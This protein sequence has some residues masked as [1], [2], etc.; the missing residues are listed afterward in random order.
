MKVIVRYTDGRLIKGFTKD[1]FPDR[2]CFHLYP[3]E[4]PQ[5]EPVEIHMTSLKAVFFVREF[6]GDDSYDERKTYMEGEN[7]S[8]EKVRVTFKDDEVMIG[9]TLGYDENRPGFFIF[10]ADPHSNNVRTYIRSSAVKKILFL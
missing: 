5:G 9:S 6:A 1:F 3:A 10:P 7:P 8:G 4:S 2:E